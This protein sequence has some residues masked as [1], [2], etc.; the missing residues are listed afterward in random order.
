MGELYIMVGMRLHSLIF[1]TIAGTP[2]L[3]IEYDA[4]IYNFL[5]IVHQ[6]NA[7]KVEA[8]DKDHFIKIMDSVLD[9]RDEYKQRINSIRDVLRKKSEQNILILKS[10]MEKGEKL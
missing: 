10:Y 4:K 5:Q 3:G 2:I 9:R 6:E 8:L 7:G 1:A